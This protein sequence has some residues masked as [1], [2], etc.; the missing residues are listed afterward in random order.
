MAPEAVEGG[1]VA[2]LKTGDKITIDATNRTI[3]HHLD[4][5]TLAERRAA[6]TPPQ[7]RVTRGVLANYYKSVASPKHGCVTDMI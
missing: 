3:D 5:A 2:F 1:P 4:A 6:W 7:P